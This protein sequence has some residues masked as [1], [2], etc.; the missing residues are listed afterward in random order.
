MMD[1]LNIL[2]IRSAILDQNQFT[3]KDLPK[4][5]PLPPITPPK[6]VPVEKELSEIL[7]KVSQIL[8]YTVK[9]LI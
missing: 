4:Q 8:N 1:D 7:S 6:K 2:A 5:L 3:S 9:I